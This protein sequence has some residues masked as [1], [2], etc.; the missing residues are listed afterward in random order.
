MASSD[1][2]ES[3][4]LL[5]VQRELLSNIITNQQEIIVTITTL[6]NSEGISNDLYESQRVGFG[7][8]SQ[9]VI[10]NTK[11]AAV[12]DL[13]AIINR[14]LLEENDDNSRTENRA[15]AEF[16]VR[17]RHVSAVVNAFKDAN[18]RTSNIR[19][20]KMTDMS[21]LFGLE[22]EVVA[23]I[24]VKAYAVRQ[25]NDDTG[26]NS[27]DK[28]DLA[29]R[30]VAAALVLSTWQ[31]E[32]IKSIKKN[33]DIPPTRGTELVRQDERDNLHSS[34]QS[35]KVLQLRAAEVIAPA[36]ATLSREVRDLAV[37]KNAEQYLQR[38]RQ[39][40]GLPTR[41]VND[42]ASEWMYSAPAQATLSREEMRDL[43]VVKNAEDLQRLRH[44]RQRQGLPTRDVNDPASGRMYSA[45][46]SSVFDP[47]DIPVMLTEFS[48]LSDILVKHN[49]SFDMIVNRIADFR[50][51]FAIGSKPPM[52]SARQSFVGSSPHTR[53]QGI[54]ADRIATFLRN[55]PRLIQDYAQ[56]RRTFITNFDREVAVLTFNN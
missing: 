40:Q 43:A 6:L 3:K 14:Q 38:L 50:S 9:L 42:P 7:F 29:K 41:D 17:C 20:L 24:L 28:Q 8:G 51:T 46:R 55:I 16:E 26:S 45:P 39:R 12:K 56:D 23:L 32:Q 13:I 19:A 35:D 36:Q 37:G 18:Y 4:R 30:K 53:M 33:L 54:H 21:S 1:V 44:Q 47:L 22:A 15:D 27:Q 31:A 10:A 5:E 52:P 25:Y 48:S 2:V 34:F 49:T 11:I